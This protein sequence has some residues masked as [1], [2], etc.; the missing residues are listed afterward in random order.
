MSDLLGYTKTTAA[1][2]LREVPVEIAD[3]LTE[4]QAVTVAQALSEYGMEVTIVDENDAYV[5][6][7]G[8]SKSSV[9]EADGMLINSAMTILATLTAANRVH[10][11]RRYRRPSFFNLLFR[12][13][14]KVVQPVHI[15]RHVSMD[16]E[17]SRRIPIQRK[18]KVATR[19]SPVYRNIGPVRPGSSPKTAEPKRKADTPVKG[20]TVNKKAPQSNKGRKKQ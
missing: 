17:P 15:R 20:G 18:P 5:D 11:Y 10:R 8:R 6:F 12:P 19:P 2:L 7:S 3:E 1:E 14:Y 13:Q 4:L 16:P 9:F